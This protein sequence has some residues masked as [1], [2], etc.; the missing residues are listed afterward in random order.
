MSKIMVKSL[1]ILEKSLKIVDFVAE[2]ARF[3]QRKGVLPLRFAAAF[4]KRARVGSGRRANREEV[5]DLWP[6]ASRK[7]PKRRHTGH[8]LCLYGTIYGLYSLTHQAHM[9][10]MAIRRAYMAY[11]PLYVGPMGPIWPYVWLMALRRSTSP[12]ATCGPT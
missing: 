12:W 5:L 3:R 7:P 1:K 2:K 11:I 10:Y 6:K 8:T 9:A 4:R